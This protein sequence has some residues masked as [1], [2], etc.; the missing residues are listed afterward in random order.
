MAKRAYCKNTVKGR[1]RGRKYPAEVRAAVVMAMISSNSICAV[2]RKYGVPE[3]TI[4]SWMA[5]EAAKPD[6]EFARARAEAAREIAARAALGA[7]AQVEYLQQRVAENRRGAD[8]RAKLGRMLDEDARA[9]LPE[10]GLQLK[11]QDE[12]AADAAETGLVVYSSPG[13]YDRQLEDDA[14]REISTQLKR[15]EAVAM[16]DKDAAAV[17]RVLLAVADRAAALAPADSSHAEAAAPA[18]LMIEREEDGGREVV[19]DGTV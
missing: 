10:I 6:G 16:S 14:R 8:I 11:S 9:R 7:K 15:Y 13:S 1:Q 19:L 5:E 12:D 2:A 3:S 4:R 18:V 17:A